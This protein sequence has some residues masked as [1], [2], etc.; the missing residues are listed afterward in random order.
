M[1]GFTLGTCFSGTW[2]QGVYIA[3]QRKILAV[4]KCICYQEKRSFKGESIQM[5]KQILEVSGELRMPKLQVIFFFFFWEA[6]TNDTNS[7]LY[8][9]DRAAVVP[10]VS[11]SA[12]QCSTPL[13]AA[14]P[15]IQHPWMA[16]TAPVHPHSPLASSTKLCAFFTNPTTA[17]T[18]AECS[19][20]LAGKSGKNSFLPVGK[21]GFC[22][23]EKTTTL[24]V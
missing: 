19:G 9:Q 24:C 7:L 5:K 17:P 12:A 21:E 11:T 2:G 6:R 4:E 22:F 23:C 1:C 13:A 3:M 8:P 16:T 15:Q 14:T 20:I 18:S 10:G